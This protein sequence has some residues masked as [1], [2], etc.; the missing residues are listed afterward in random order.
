MRVAPSCTTVTRGAGNGRGTEAGDPPVVDRE[1]VRRRL[2]DASTRRSSCRT[3][4]DTFRRPDVVRARA[5]LHRRDAAGTAGSHG[6]TARPPN[7]DACAA[8]PVTRTGNGRPSIESRSERHRCRA[9][10]PARGATCSPGMPSSAMPD[11][12]GHGVAG[13]LAASRA[14]CGCR[15]I[16]TRMRRPVS[17]G[18][19]SG[20][21]AV[22]FS[23]GRS[24][25][26]RQRDLAHRAVD[27]RARSRSAPSGGRRRRPAGPCG[28][29]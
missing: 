17:A 11:R 25:D 4:P 26:R 27:L 15:S 21:V 14:A 29:T 2:P 28:R 20:T 23:D 5:Q 12:R 3:R 6:A 13:R 16:V 1:R 7:C 10:T 9:A 18:K 8:S 22:A 24:R 19:C